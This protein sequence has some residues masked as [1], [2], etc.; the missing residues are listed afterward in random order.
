M[1]IIIGLLFLLLVAALIKPN[2]AIFDKV[3][4]F[5]NKGKGVRRLLFFAVWFILT[6]ICTLVSKSPENTDKA[7]IDTPTETP[8]SDYVV[9][10]D[11]AT[12][13]LKGQDTL[14][15]DGKGN[16]EWTAVGMN[17]GSSLLINIELTQSVGIYPTSVN[18][19]K[20]NYDGLVYGGFKFYEG[21][22][23][24]VG[25]YDFKGEDGTVRVGKANDHGSVITQ[26]DYKH[27]Q[28]AIELDCKTQIRPLQLYDIKS[29]VG[30]VKVY[31]Q[32][33]TEGKS[34]DAKRE[35]TISDD[36]EAFNAILNGIF[37]DGND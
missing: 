34:Q 30:A 28:S 35:Y 37:P 33:V 13:I 7:V 9:S 18:F 32:N 11:S 17:D 3:P 5:R 24:A 14:R 2:A 36:D 4:M 26:E 12:V 6:I 10:A 21:E 15:F 25:L 22:Y 16:I 20:T 8:K 29:F 19:D 27:L 1:D 31:A 23:G